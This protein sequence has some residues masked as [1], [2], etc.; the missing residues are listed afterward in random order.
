MLT[1]SIRADGAAFEPDP[2]QEVARILR[3]LA[4]RIEREGVPGDRSLFDANGNKV[5]HMWGD[6]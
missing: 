5:G 6:K 1:I 4:D 3:V 2:A